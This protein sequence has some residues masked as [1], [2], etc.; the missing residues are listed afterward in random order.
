MVLEWP[1]YFKGII[2]NAQ[3]LSL[4][5]LVSVYFT[6]AARKTVFCASYLELLPQHVLKM[7]LAYLS[8]DDAYALLLA[9]PRLVPETCGLLSS[10]DVFTPRQMHVPLMDEAR[11]MMLRSVDSCKFLCL[12]FRPSSE[13]LLT[14]F[15]RLLNASKLER[16]YVNNAAAI[17]NEE[18]SRS[19]RKVVFYFDDSHKKVDVWS[20]W[21]LAVTD[22]CRVESVTVDMTELLCSARDTVSRRRGKE[23]FSAFPHLRSVDFFGLPHDEFW[24]S[25]PPSATEKITSLRFN[26][27]FS[28]RE[29]FL[30]KLLVNRF[31][32]LRELSI[33][34]GPDV[35][36]S[37]TNAKRV[38]P[39]LEKLELVEVERPAKTSEVG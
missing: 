7:V 26:C 1:F 13:P 25:C 3:I 30:E 11:S 31:D 39:A 22:R 14:K 21:S 28:S 16:L 35:L 9:S 32:S 33:S 38:L 23:F 5:D 20:Q 27:L 10:S 37:L 24:T 6:L 34:Y 36:T 4:L 29:D 2:L 18:V 8:L 15:R 19:L 17:E 12:T